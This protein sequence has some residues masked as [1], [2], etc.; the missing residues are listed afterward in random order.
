MKFD[1]LDRL[2][3]AFPDIPMR[4]LGFPAAAFV[5]LHIEQGP[6]LDA[7]RIP[8]GVVS[9]IQGKKTYRISVVGEK[10]HAGTTPRRARKDALRAAAAMIDTLHREIVDEND[11]VRFTVGRI[12]VE[13]NAPSVVPAKVTFSVDLRHPGAEAL[14]GFGHQLERT[15]RNLAAPCTAEIEPLVDAA[16]LTFASEL[17]G[18]IRSTADSLAMPLIELPSAAGHDARNLNMVCPTAMIFV[19][20]KDGIS[21][22]EAESVLITDIVA[23]TKVFVEVIA[24]LAAHSGKADRSL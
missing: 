20:C 8:I 16:P 12:N 5:E 6:V 11:V 15:C 18:L 4:P 22:N 3:A 9:G 13:P 1:E 23:G 17:R 14:N 7:A 10:A 24:Q 19:P 21:H 2:F